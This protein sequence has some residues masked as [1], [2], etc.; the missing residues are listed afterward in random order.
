MSVMAS[1]ITSLTI[2]YSIF[3]SSADQRKYQSSASL[4]FVRGIHRWLVNS[5]HKGPV[6]WKMFT[7]DDV[8]MESNTMIF[9]H[10]YVVLILHV[11]VLF[12][13]WPKRSCEIAQ[14]L[15][16][17]KCR[18][19][20]VYFVLVLMCQNMR[21]VEMHNKMSS[22][23]FQWSSLW[24]NDCWRIVLSDQTINQR[25]RSTLIQVTAYCLTAAKHY[26]NKS[27]SSKQG[28]IQCSFH[29]DDKI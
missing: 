4:A 28:N 27:W 21:H 1:Q 10:V 19:R 9:I 25:S 3:Y 7:F 6:T 8:I 14:Q 22:A 2:V 29:G 20:N 12:S 13:T 26:L 18:L 23:I 11:S 17:L 16:R 15:K 24:V 5:P